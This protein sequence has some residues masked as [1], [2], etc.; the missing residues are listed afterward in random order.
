[1]Q[2][3]HRPHL[4]F[5]GYSEAQETEAIWGRAQPLPSPQQLQPGDPVHSVYEGRVRPCMPPVTGN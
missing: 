4:V 1:M 2:G 5:S 3:R